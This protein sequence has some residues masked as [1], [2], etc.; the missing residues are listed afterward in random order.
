MSLESN[1]YKPEMKEVLMPNLKIARL[2]STVHE[3]TEFSRTVGIPFEEHQLQT[4]SFHI[5]TDTIGLLEMMQEL[6]LIGPTQGVPHLSV[7]GK[8]KLEYFEGFYQHS[9]SRSYLAPNGYGVKGAGLVQSNIS[10]QNQAFGIGD[11]ISRVNSPDI[12]GGVTEFSA[13]SQ[14]EV[15]QNLYR[16]SLLETGNS[17]F[18]RIYSCLPF[19]NHQTF[20][21]SK[22]RMQQ[23]SLII[24]E[25]GVR[26]SSR[27]K[28]L[29]SLPEFLPLLTD[30]AYSA[31]D[32]LEPD[33]HNVFMRDGKVVLTDY[34]AT[35]NMLKDY[36]VYIN[37][38]ANSWYFEEMRKGFNNF[39]R[40]YNFM[41]YDNLTTVNISDIIVELQKSLETSIYY[42]LD[43]F[44]DALEEADPK[45]IIRY[46][47]A[48]VLCS[49]AKAREIGHG[50]LKK[51]IQ[52]IIT[53]NPDNSYT[54][55]EMFATLTQEELSGDFHGQGTNQE[56]CRISSDGPLSFDVDLLT[57]GLPIDSDI[58]IPITLADIYLSWPLDD[59]S[60]LAEVYLPRNPFAEIPENILIESPYSKVISGLFNIKSLQTRSNTESERFIGYDLEELRN[61]R[62]LYRQE[63]DIHNLDLSFNYNDQIIFEMQDGSLL[64]DTSVNLSSI[65]ASDLNKLAYMIH[66][67]IL[68]TQQN[69]LA[70]KDPISLQIDISE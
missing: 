3:T 10:Q 29:S 26:G 37:E 11:Y 56:I 62:Y 44:R 5:G 47:M 27:K 18:A 49:R 60:E 2:F 15:A 24:R 28:M 50:I 40:I 69:Q 21:R 20:S 1:E 46:A 55:E 19:I 23:S 7:G 45:Q 22:E 65:S 64:I 59:V 33:G 16:L 36:G 66:A 54:L 32:F 41:P 8:A 43:D 35:Y 38:Y 63:V 58:R 70:V 6:D 48:S 61:G 68:Q 25:D 9:T 53:A 17:S 57:F 14:T 42:D 13:E 12:A 51:E 67:F 52:R 39:A 31:N 4:C 30:F 34:E